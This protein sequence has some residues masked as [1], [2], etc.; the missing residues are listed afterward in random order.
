M[1]D[2]SY[3]KKLAKGLNINDI[4]SLSVIM[5]PE[6]LKERIKN[7]TLSDFDDGKTLISLHSHTN[8]SDGQLKPED[9][10]KNAIQFKEE[11]GYK[12]LILAITD[13]DS[14]DALL[15]ALKDAQKNY[16]KYKNIR[17]VLG[18]EL[19]LSYF[20]EKLRRPVDFE[21]LH[22][23]INPF[24]KKYDKFL[25]NAKKRKLNAFPEIFSFFENRYPSANINL[26]DFLINFPKNKFGFGCYAAYD[27]PR[28][29]C[30]RVNNPAEDE[31]IWD[32][33]RR[34]GS[35]FS[36]LSQHPFWFSV[37]EV[38]EN[39]KKHQF[40]FLSIAHPYRIQLEGK[41]QENGT[42]FLNRFFSVLKEKGVEGLETFYMNLH[43]PL[44]S[45]LDRMLENNYPLNDTDKWVKTILDFAKNNQMIQTGGTDSHT[46]FLAGRKR[47]IV[48]ELTKMLQ[49]FKPLIQAGYNV[50][51][52]E[53]TL[54]L[55]AP[56]MPAKSAYENTG[57]GSS[58]GCGAKRIDDFFGGLFDK[59][60][61]GPMGKTNSKSKHSPYVSS[62]KANPFFI[63]L[64]K[65]VKD[66]LL[67]EKTLYSIY[68]IQKSDTEIDFDLVEKAYDKALKEA[69]QKSKTNLSFDDF[70]EQLANKY[71]S[72]NAVKYI[73][74]LQVHIPSDTEG[75]TE[76]LFLKGFSLGA[77][78]DDFSPKPRNWGF[79][80]FNPNLLFDND[81]NL[82]PAGKVWYNIIDKT[83]KNAKGG[84]RVDHYIG[85]V[86][87][88]VI[89][90]ENPDI[91]GRLYSSPHISELSDFVKTDFSNITKKILLDAAQKNGL[92]YSD[93]YVEDVGKRP[94]QL[95]N[96]MQECHLGRLLISQF[97]EPTN[98]NHMYHF[99]KAQK[100]DVACLDTHDLPSIHSFFENMPD[101]KKGEFAWHL[102]QDLRFNYNDDLKS[103][104][105]L[106]RM[107]WG[108][109]L[110][111]PAKR[112]QAF[113]TSWTGQKG[114]YN[115]SGNPIKWKL[116]CDVNFDKLYFENL[117]KGI[118]YNPFD[119]IALAIYARGDEF[120]H[121][122][123]ALVHQLRKA[124]EEILN[125]AKQL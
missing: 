13:H 7:L 62:S 88:F 55:P 87:P 26:E 95:D 121:Q 58:Y 92:T 28:Y 99:A 114:R 66:N 11:Y 5:G 78:G 17:L 59:I 81:G 36:E 46:D 10:L 8:A 68:D 41:V 83:M 71:Q 75:L 80:V 51:D 48:K 50:L 23:G 104:S 61:L 25:K 108:A 16:K 93:I 63:P 43:Q 14:I 89:N 103:T 120:Y 123:E 70:I 84:L 113:F 107:M 9:Y 34:L 18:C 102:A 45:S 33:F 76:D 118:A 40:G 52:K 1:F 116:R 3:L 119:A 73:A 30:Q 24:D 105:Q 97:W 38:I 67:T 56:C 39:F 77:P 82:G 6:E 72:E 74:D 31:F 115:Q 15:P 12:E 44:S 20:D 29:I 110:A 32:Y 109:L 117:A 27:A 122:N 42:D 2:E 96:V 85:F 21:M 94:E 35:P 19:S 86:N 100:T 91:C 4:K 69:Y 65:L 22:Y 124:E 37:D 79:I 54:G 98:Y 111:C 47:K 53:V 64:E 90:D 106:T 60:Q 112:V 101:Y 125:L 49:Q 57:I